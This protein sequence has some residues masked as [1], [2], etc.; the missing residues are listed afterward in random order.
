MTAKQ[1]KLHLIWHSFK[2]NLRPGVRGGVAG[3][4]HNND[5]GYLQCYIEP[6]LVLLL[7][8]LLLG[9]EV[10]ASAHILM[11]RTVRT[12]VWLSASGFIR[13]DCGAAQCELSWDW[14]EVFWGFWWLQKLTETDTQIQKETET[15]TD[16]GRARHVRL[17]LKSACYLHI[18]TRCGSICV[19]FWL[20]VPL[21][22]CV[23]VCEV[24]VHRFPRHQIETLYKSVW[25]IHNRSTWN[26]LQPTL[27]QSY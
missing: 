1:N 26:H 16:R 11:W 12:L 27:T 14:N 22:V 13:P 20:S 9:Y 18:I 8:L 3:V 6:Q 17:P 19:C 4:M 24:C 7:L 2:F 23:R 25:Q 5:F 15:E 21:S 10:N